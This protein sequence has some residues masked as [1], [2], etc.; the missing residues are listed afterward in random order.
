MMLSVVLLVAIAGLAAGAPNPKPS[1]VRQCENIECPDYTQLQVLRPDM[2]KMSVEP[3]RWVGKM[4]ETCNRTDAFL[5][6]FKY[7]DDY[8]IDNGMERTLPIVLEVIKNKQR[9][10]SRSSCSR[11]MEESY[12]CC[13]EFYNL[14]F[15]IPRASQES[16]PYP[17][18]ESGMRLYPIPYTLVFYVISFDGHPTNQNVLEKFQEITEYLEDRRIPFEDEYYYIASEYCW[19]G[20]MWGR[21]MGD[22]RVFLDS[23]N[24]MNK[25]T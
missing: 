22:T 12:P 24:R 19:G 8:F 16:A 20:A 13:E 6:V 9:W 25:A 10:D 14:L 3:G 2:W 17:S 11:Q 1:L 23:G 18:E 7:L 21:V 5:S 4:A 15:Y